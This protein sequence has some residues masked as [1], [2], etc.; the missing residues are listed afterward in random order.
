MLYPHSLLWHYLW[1]GPNVLQLVLAVLLWRRGF[2]RQFAAF[3]IY[4]VY[5]AV[6]QFTLW[7]LGV[8]PLSYVGVHPFWRAF[9]VGSA[10]E[11]FVKLT[12]IWALFTHLVGRRPSI[13]R[14]STRLIV[15]VGAALVALALLAA[16]HT[17][18]D[19]RKLTLI[20]RAQVFEMVSYIV[21]SGLILFVFVFAAYH[22]LTWGRRSLGIALGLGI[23]WC[24]HMAAWTL[25]ASWLLREKGYLL[26]FLNMGT[27]HACVLLWF[28]YFLSPAQQGADSTHDRISLDREVGREK[29]S[30]NSQGQQKL[31]P[32]W[33]LGRSRS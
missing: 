9:I 4:L 20:F 23:V 27:Y 31:Q 2:N 3:F 29:G 19:H 8:L 11:D 13:V 18:M 5:G 1:V 6:E 26:D 16:A 10:I 17:P 25:A 21:L 12:L 24:E 33:F 28:Y 15:G 7:T 14:S 30:A 22:W 32:A